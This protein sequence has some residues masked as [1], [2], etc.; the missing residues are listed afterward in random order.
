MASEYDALIVGARVAG[1]SLAIRLAQQGRRV[2]L[3][4]RDAFPSDTIS[5]HGLGFTAVESLRRLGVLERV[6]AAGFRR[7]YRHRAWL[8][9]VFIEAPAGP[10]GAYTLAP[11]RL[12]LDQILAERAVECGAELLE[13]ARVD[14]LL[15]ESGVIVGAVVQKLGGERIEL[16]ARVVI[17]ADGKGSQVAKW[18]EAEKYDEGRV[19]RPIYYGYFR[20]TE[21]L[22][23]PTAEVFFGSDHV[24]FCLAMRP[25]EHMLALEVQPEEFD[26]IRRDPRAWL[27]AACRSLPGMDR[28][29]RDATL[30][31]Q[32]RGVRGVENHLRKPFGPG[33]ALTGDA[34]YVKDPITAYGVGDA[35]LQG[36]LLARALG[37]WFDGAPWESTLSD[38]QVRRD[39]TFRAL[40]EQTLAA[41]DARDGGEQTLDELRAAL[42]NPQDAAQVL[43]ALPRFFDQVFQPMDRFRHGALRNMIESA[44]EV[45]ATGAK[46]R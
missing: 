44:R 23:D 28:R 27:I 46:N 13:R 39:T 31:G 12:V 11:R 20:G 43:R 22:P 30:D 38:Y 3:V 8:G 37:A 16:R 21:S 32:V 33:W 9:D 17:G 15:S 25:D 45:S 41:L 42:T 14:A 26:H 29:M 19:G 10:P 5:T 40:Y 36:F 4:D 35:M 2:L 24:A 34:G 6:E 7:M 1:S 18:V